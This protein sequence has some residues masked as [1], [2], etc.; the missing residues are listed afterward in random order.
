MYAHVCDPGTRPEKNRLIRVRV[1][2]LAH[3]YGCKRMYMSARAQ[4]HASVCACVRARTSCMHAYVCARMHACTRV[5]VM[6]ACSC[7]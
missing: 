3:M 2:A 7:V 4:T 6:Y 5:R 1:R